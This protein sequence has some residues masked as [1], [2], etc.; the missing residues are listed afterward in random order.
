MTSV[1]TQDRMWPRQAV[2]VSWTF[3]GRRVKRIPGSIDT[4]CTALRTGAQEESLGSGSIVPGDSR[5]FLTRAPRQPPQL[6]PPR[7][8]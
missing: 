1:V 4:A 5:S 7:A 6:E 3:H 8:A 2:D